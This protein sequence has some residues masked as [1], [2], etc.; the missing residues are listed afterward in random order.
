MEFPI[1]HTKRLL[2]REW[3]VS[4]AEAL[5]SLYGDEDV[6]RYTPIS[7][8]KNIETAEKKIERFRNGFREKHDSIVWAVTS[9]DNGAI[10]GECSI[11]SLTPE[12]KRLELG[13]SFTRDVWGKGIANESVKKVIDFAFNDFAAF[14]VNRIEACTDPRNISSM[15]LLEKLGFTKEGC[16]RQ[17][18]IEKGEFVDSVIYGLLKA[19]YVK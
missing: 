3:E 17:H 10:L 1:L 2:L 19:E 12:H 8:F 18:E 7:T 14:D 9:K 4:D 13:C 16:L 6:V 11:H 15:K 5:L